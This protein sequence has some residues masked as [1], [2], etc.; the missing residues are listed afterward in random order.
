MKNNIFSTTLTLFLAIIML[1]AKAQKAIYLNAR[2]IQ[3]AT[4]FD[5]KTVVLP[6]ETDV[7]NHKF[8]RLV[9]FNRL[10]MP[11]EKAEMA[12]K[13][14]E[15]MDYIPDNAFVLSFPI[16]FDFSFLSKYDVKTVIILRGPDKM[17]DALRN[18][19]FPDFA[20]KTIGKYDLTVQP[21]A[22]V[23][24]EQAA[25][26]LQKQGFE[27]VGL[28]NFFFKTVTIRVKKADMGRVSDLPYVRFIDFIDGQ[29]LK[30]N[31][32]SH[33]QNRGNM[34]NTDGRAG[35][36]YDGTNFGI[37]FADDGPI[38]PHIDFQGR[39]TQV[40]DFSSAGGDIDHA[41]MTAGSAVA[42]GNLDP[43]LKSGASGANLISQ[44][45]DN[46]P[47]IQ[48]A[49]QNQ[50][51]YRAYI[52]S[53]SYGQGSP[54]S[55]EAGCNKY[56]TYT[57]QIDVQAFTNRRLFHVFSAGNSGA[58]T[59]IGVPTFGN[60][61]GGF[62]LG[63]NVI[64]VGNLD[65][66]DRLASSS[67]RGP[68]VDGRIKPDICALGTNIY[69]TF[70]N[71]TTNTTSGT[72]ISAPAVAAAAAQLYHAYSDLNDGQI[73]DA[74]LIK[75]VLLNT[76]DDLGNTGPD[77]FYGWGRVNAWR[78]YLTLKDKR[79]IKSSVSRTDS[80]VKFP[81]TVPAGVKQVKIMAYWP[82]AGAAPNAAKALINDL[83]LTVKNVETGAIFLPWT[84][85]RV[86]N[87]DS[88]SQKARRGSDH[89]NNVEQVVIDAAALPALGT[90]M[91][92]VAVNGFS[93][94]NDVQTFYL[95]YEFNRN[96]VTVTYPNGGEA[97]AI[98]STEQIRW[99]APVAHD[100]LGI[101]AL[102]FSNN[103]GVTWQGITTGIPASTR[104]FSWTVPN[105]VTSKACVRARY[106]MNDG[107]IISDLSDDL[108]TVSK[109]T[110]KLVVK[111]VCPDSTYLSFD[112]VPGAKSYQIC[113]LG[114]KY[115]D[116]IMVSNLNLVAV[117][118]KWSDSAWY[119]VRPILPDGSLGRRVNAVAKPRNLTVCPTTATEE[120][121][122][123]IPMLAAFPNPSENGLF[124]LALKNF[125]YQSLSVKV[126]DAMGKE[127][128]TKKLGQVVGDF[129]Q[130]FDLKNE[131][132]GVYLIQIQTEK[133]VYSLKVTK[134]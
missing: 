116:S 20:Q 123:S 38:D 4:D 117:P 127:V 67:S 9:Q 12:A 120:G 92:E 94:P 78:A 84:L 64:A 18:G 90:T 61:T 41:D 107:T 102:D 11:T 104:N 105:D 79:Y 21:Y 7:F 112:T 70:P 22:N 68:S 81:L 5:V 97:L 88:L 82:D 129:Q 76:A 62:K 33:Q 63:K 65:I 109:L 118:Q 101:F 106:A 29:P 8:Y 40:Q 73:P 17:S 47:H 59:C 71:N 25:I 39:L 36:K 75:S 83:D 56:N 14:A 13:G 114:A 103:G 99:D 86:L 44:I 126:F 35:L 34:L 113:R 100:S 53:T 1:S 72:S 50:F 74:A 134:Q 46:Y 19:I 32:K 45:I 119:S 60:I 49:E 28:P 130:V 98:G 58:G 108:F 110:T 55:N 2:T 52:T 69:T 115:M 91:L 57:N 131:P 16:D 87:A 37:S 80:I 111:Y 3:T 24:L 10:P 95:V 122:L 30:E 27:M 42:A 43:A 121:P 15:I 6:T 26:D 23:S 31:D 133:K 128:L 89:V 96:D 85:G 77:F 93:L 124:T 125:D 51:I 132:S 48:D 54:G 66:N